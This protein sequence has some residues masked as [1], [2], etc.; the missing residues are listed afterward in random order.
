MSNVSTTILEHLPEDASTDQD[1]VNVGPTQTRE[2]LYPYGKDQWDVLWVGHFGVEYTSKTAIW[3]Y[4]DPH[5]LPWDRV[6]SKFNNYYST[7]PKNSQQQVLH[8]IA[9]MASYAFGLTRSAAANLISTLR[10]ERAQKFDLAL[11][12]QCK[13]LG[14][15][16][17]AP[18]PGLM[19]HHKVDGQRSILDAGNQDDGKHDLK[20]WARHHKYTY[21]LA[22]SARCTAGKSGEKLGDSWRCMPGLY[23]ENL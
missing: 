10:R 17:V 8:S 22:T 21:N 11:H 19:H 14:L 7:R 23:D 9:P 2:A 20:W 5:A 12:I 3:E 16:C 18:A 13:G 15:L 4:R 1:S 6:R